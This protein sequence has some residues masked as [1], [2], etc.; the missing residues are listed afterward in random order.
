MC[1]CGG[2]G[3]GVCK[4]VESVCECVEEACVSVGV[5]GGVCGWGVFEYR[6][7]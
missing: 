2:G 3:R 1:K 5:C 4:Y 7:V 6:C